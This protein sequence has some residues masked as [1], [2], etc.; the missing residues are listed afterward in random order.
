M[1]CHAPHFRLEQVEQVVWDWIKNLLRDPQVLLEGL[2]AYLAETETQ[3]NPFRERLV[4]AENLSDQNN[5]ELE[6]ALD[7]YLIDKFP[8][9]V[10]ISRKNELETALQSLEHD[11]TRLIKVIEEQ[12][13]SPGQIKDVLEFALSDRKYTGNEGPLGEKFSNLS[14]H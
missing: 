2:S 12:P 14:I 5:R 1:T 3:I 7:L 4:V 10:L 11:Q 6:S 9:E 8:K 13:I